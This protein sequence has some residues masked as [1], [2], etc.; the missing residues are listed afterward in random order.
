MS[1]MGASPVRSTLYRSWC[2]AV[3]CALA[4]LIFATLA[5]AQQPRRAKEKGPR[6]LGLLELSAN[7]NARL[8]PLTIMVDGKFYDA[9]DYKE[10]T[11]PRARWGQAGYVAENTGRAE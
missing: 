8:I 7:G 5:G 2:W 1:S 6:A 9:S 10:S 4:A 11:G 3:I